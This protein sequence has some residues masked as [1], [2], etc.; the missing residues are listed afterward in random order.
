MP[1]GKTPVTAA[2]ISWL[3]VSMS[4]GQRPSKPPTTLMPS[5]ASSSTVAIGLE[6]DR[7][8]DQLQPHRR[9]IAQ[10]VRL[11]ESADDEDL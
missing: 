11:V 3:S 8:V 4:T 2:M 6:R 9:V 1:G 5:P 10:D 7:A